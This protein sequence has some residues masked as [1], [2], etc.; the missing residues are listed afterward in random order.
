M[1]AIE[2]FSVHKTY[3][4]AEADF[5]NVGKCGY[6]AMRILRADLLQAM[7]ELPNE[8]RGK[9]HY[10]KNLVE[11]LESAQGIEVRFKGGETLLADLL[12]GCDGI[13]SRT[14]NMFVD[15]DSVPVYTGVAAA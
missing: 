10:G 3:K 15:P 13:H 12:L 14:R 1:H 4:I 2:I 11:I 9:L 8:A 5:N 7:L 6:N